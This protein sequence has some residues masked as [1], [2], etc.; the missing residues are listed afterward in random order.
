[1]PKAKI[2][3]WDTEAVYELVSAMLDAVKNW[4]ED[5][6]KR[7]IVDTYPETEENL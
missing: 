3:A 5:M 7:W 6:V 4:N 1:M 2:E